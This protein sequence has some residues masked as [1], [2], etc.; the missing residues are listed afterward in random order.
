M[1]V[2]KYN[3][4]EIWPAIFEKISTGPRWPLQT[5]PLMATQT[6]PGRTV[7]IVM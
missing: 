5:P 1:A 4:D 3:A 6:P 7:E 2:T